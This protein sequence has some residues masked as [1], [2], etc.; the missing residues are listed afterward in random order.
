MVR[1]SSVNRVVRVVAIAIQTWSNYRAIDV[2]C[3]ELQVVDVIV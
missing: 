3:P 2:V 1:S